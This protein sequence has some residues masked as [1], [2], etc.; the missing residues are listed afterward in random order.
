[1]KRYILTALLFF[2]FFFF[3]FSPSYAQENFT[4]NNDV[5]YTV[6]ENDLTQARLAISLTNTTS[7]YYA[8][9]YAIRIGFSHIE[10]VTA[11][12]P[13]GPITPEVIKQG[14]GYSIKVRFNQPVVG[15]NKTL[16]FVIQFYT[17]DILQEEGNIYEVDIPGVANQSDFSSFTVHVR[18]PGSFGEPTYIKPD[19]GKR[20]LDFTKEELGSGGVSIAF[21]KSQR[22]DVSLTYHIEN[23]HVFPIRTEIALPPTTNYQEVLLDSIEPKPLQ[24]KQDEDG[25]W[26]AQYSLLP[27]QELDILV[28]GTIHV[29]LFPKEHQ[30]TKQSLEKYLRPKKYWDVRNQQIQRLAKEL[31]TPENIYAYVIKTL[32]YDFS[33]VSERKE[34]LGAS[35][36]L[37]KPD[38][39]V[40][41]EF[42]D[43]FIAIARAAGIPAREIDGFGYTQ[44]EIAR[45][46]LLDDDI[47]HAWPEYYDTVKK[48]WIMVDPTWGNTTRGVDY[49]DVLDFNHIT[50]VIKGSDSMYPIPAGGYKLPGKKINKD[51][52]ITPTKGVVF[53]AAFAKVTVQMQ[54]K[55]IAGTPISGTLHITNPGGVLYPPQ[56][57]YIENSDLTPNRQKVQ[58]SQIP[59]FGFTTVPFGFDKIG[60]FTAKDAKMTVLIG[61]ERVSANIKIIPMY[62]ALFQKPFL[63]WTIGGGVC[64]AVITL[65][66]FVITRRTRN[67]SVS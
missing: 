26:L 37:Q 17:P 29:F 51:V 40:C 43:L 27:S 34:R 13:K 52:V 55:T 24:V 57:I 3:S 28:K 41:L 38:S 7:Q 11:S 25:N 4:I 53:P 32:S 14:D 46:L 66:I 56:D 33:R 67:L 63:P 35:S 18:V 47:L 54:D 42:T 64:L 16:P 45:P 15:I 6:V 62:Q 22:Y 39:A 50:F 48:T 49:F 8:S 9:E 1:M 23:T 31:K 65:I 58:V 10:R 44:N 36:V 61:G 60:F 2:L 19:T 21:G 20:D 59:P 30:E 5:T 12:D